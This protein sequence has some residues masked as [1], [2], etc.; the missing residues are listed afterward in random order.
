MPKLGENEDEAETEI[1]L[2]EEELAAHH[3]KTLQL[4]QKLE[5]RVGLEQSLSTSL[6][7]FGDEEY[8]VEIP[9]LRSSDEILLDKIEEANTQMKYFGYTINN[10]EKKQVAESISKVIKMEKP[11]EPKFIVTFEKGMNIS[12]KSI[13]EA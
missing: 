5:D 11:R 2:L 7:C 10:L 4:F 12:K 8:P 6:F 13:P 9:K 3:Q 1:R